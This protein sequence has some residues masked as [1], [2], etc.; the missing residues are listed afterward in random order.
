[1][2]FGFSSASFGAGA[3]SAMSLSCAVSPAVSSVS[4]KSS[5]L[6]ASLTASSYSSTASSASVNTGSG[7]TAPSCDLL[8]SMTC[9]CLS[10]GR[11]S[12]RSLRS[13]VRPLMMSSS[14]RTYFSAAFGVS[15]S[16]IASAASSRILSSILLTALPE[17]SSSSSSEPL[18]AA[19]AA[20]MSSVAESALSSSSKRPSSG[21][22][23]VSDAD[24]A[25]SLPL[26]LSFLKNPPIL[27]VFSA[28]GAAS[29]IASAGASAASPRA[30]IAVS[31]SSLT[32]D[33][34][35]TIISSARETGAA[36]FTSASWASR[37]IS[38]S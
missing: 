20:S 23:S 37:R 22:S 4:N 26:F 6:T 1:M 16:A 17:L 2:T 11:A 13:G 33:D 18:I 10:A 36:A 12:K 31:T 5:V 25:S 29:S 24:F 35:F 21:A 9:L 32:A 8:M 34:E 3:S 14:V 19:I 28:S 38:S 27:L 15:M 7:A 30:S